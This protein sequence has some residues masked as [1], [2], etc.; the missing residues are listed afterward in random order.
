MKHLKTYKLFESNLDI[1]SQ[2]DDI[3]LELKDEGFKT[4]ISSP[5]DWI[6]E[7]VISKSDFEWSDVNDTLLRLKDFIES[8]GYILS[9]RFGQCESHS[10]Y[11]PE[12]FDIIRTKSTT[13]KFEK[14]G[15]VSESIEY[16][17]GKELVEDCFLPVSDIVWVKITDLQ[18]P[19]SLT[20][21]RE[22]ICVQINL[23]S[24]VSQTTEVS[25]FGQEYHPVVDGD[26]I[27]E[28]ISSA[29]NH[30]TGNGL[31]LFRAEVRWKNAGEWSEMNP[32]KTGIGP[33]FL[34]TFFTVNG[35]E[36][37]SWETNKGKNWTT[38]K[39]STSLAPDFILSRGD[40]LRSVKLYFL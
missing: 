13:L 34:D 37:K 17:S 29:I 12:T 9:S 10:I 14:S 7:V 36:Q 22:C 33:G 26:F 18:V 23:N 28:E 1:I 24:R 38:T 25:E 3:L 15:Q 31:S 5:A 40:L 19:N 11:H 20:I 6:I 27:C 30:C 32:D 35:S 16:S 39:H 21:K 4:K 2:C 8:N